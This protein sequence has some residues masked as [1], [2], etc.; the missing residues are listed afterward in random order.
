[1]TRAFLHFNT[2]IPYALEG[3]SVPV[4]SWK[5]NTFCIAPTALS[6]KVL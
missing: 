5:T 3:L 2:L 4:K 6:R 1:M